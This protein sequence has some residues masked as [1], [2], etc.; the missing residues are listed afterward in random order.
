MEY[1]S[2]Q[3]MEIL[4]EMTQTK[5]THL[6]NIDYVPILVKRHILINVKKIHNVVKNTI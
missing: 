2:D 5:L 3:K 4:L 1:A 6:M